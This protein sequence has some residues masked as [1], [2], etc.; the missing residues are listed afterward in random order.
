MPSN[1]LTPDELH[2]FDLLLTEH[3]TE[4][5]DKIQGLADTFAGVQ[6]ARSDGSTDGAH[7]AEASS[8]RTEWSRMS[9]FQGEFATELDAIDR[10][11]ARVAD[12]SYG[13]CS[14]GGERIGQERLEYRPASELCIDCARQLE[15]SRRR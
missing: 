15:S 7:D 13:F 11:L 4:I 10:A 6:G 8:L 9:K 12:G 3:R 5:T 1:P 14:R 2:A